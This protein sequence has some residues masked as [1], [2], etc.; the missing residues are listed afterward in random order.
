MPTPFT[1]IPPLLVTDRECLEAWRRNPCAESLRPL[2]E[3]Y[4][5]FVHSSAHR[6][7]GNGD[8]AAEVTRA[9]FLVLARR[10]RKLR[11]KTVLAGWLFHVT[12]LACRKLRRKRF[13]TLRRLFNWISRRPRHSLPLGAPLWTRVAPKIDRALERLRSKQ[14]NAVL[15]RAFLNYDSASTANILRSRAP[16]IEKRLGRGLKKVARRLRKRRAPVD[17]AALA[18]ACAAE[19]CATPVPDGLALDI[20]QAIEASRR[21][22]PSFKLARRTSRALA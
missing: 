7:T 8:D 4:G 20:L 10:A 15:L 2:L 16:R 17:P 12:A 5:A 14:R 22:C 18:A 9:V 3:R 6:R 13:G 21:K 11:K 19:G 1:A